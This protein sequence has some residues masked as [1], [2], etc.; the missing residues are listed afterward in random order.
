MRKFFTLMFVFGIV[1][2]FAQTATIKGKVTDKKTGEALIGANVV[3]DN[4]KGAAVDINGSYS[5]QTEPGTY[6]IVFKF[7]GYD[8]HEEKI[9]LA[10]NEVKTLDIKLSEGNQLEDVVVS[11]SKFEQKIGEVAISMNIIKPELIDN[12][13]ITTPEQIVDQCPGVQI[14]ENQV[15]IRGGSGFSYGSGSRVLLMVD[16]LPMLSADA[17]DIKWNSLPIENVEQMEVMKGASSVLYG[18]SALNGVINIRT[19]FPRSK[20]L[21]K[22]NISNGFYMNPSGTQKG[23]KPVYNDNGDLVG[24]EDSI[25]DRSIQQWNPNTNY[26]IA[27]NFLHSRQIKQQFDLVV[28]GNFFTNQGYRMGN[29]EHRGR[30]NFNTRYRSKKIEGLSFGVN[31]NL[32]K[33]KGADFFAWQNADSVFYPQGL[34]DTATTT[35]QYFDNIRVNLDPHATYFDNK[36]NRHML[37]S[38][39]FL[40]NNRNSANRASIANLYYVEYQYQKHWKNGLTVSFGAMNNYSTVVAPLYGNHFSNNTAA[41]AQADK[42]I[43]KFTFTGG[44]RMEYFRIDSVQTREYNKLIKDTLPFKPVFRI[45]TTYEVAEHTFLRA[46]YGEGYRFPTIAE[47]FIQTSVGALNIFPNSRLLAESG[48][49]AELG[50]KQGVKIGNFKGYL[51]IAGFV[52]GYNNMMEFTFGLYQADGSPWDYSQ[53][54]NIFTDFGAQAKNVENALIKGGEISLA[55]TGEIGKVNVTTLMGYTYIDPRTVNNEDSLY[56][57]TFSDTTNILKYRSKHMFKGDLQLDYKKFSFGV[58]AR[59]NSFQQNIDY[60]FVDPFIGSILLPGYKAYREARRKGDCI[61]DARLSMQVSKF[62]KVSVLMNNV[63]N[64]EYSSRPGNVMPPRTLIFQYSFKF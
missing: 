40:T 42:K 14:N 61:F 28:G 39:W 19:A 1:I 24:Y 16:D 2:S 45:G 35:L 4:G 58:S 20:P 30:I 8:N 52:T 7:V 63:F 11:A 62:A 57:A 59:Y 9:T 44:M 25:I 29:D 27:A 23:T 33:T 10:A 5:I 38:R 43:K 34:E 21:T 41:F 51:D 18:S 55:G 13:A 64:R 56:M 15:S 49:S 47:K 26:Y 46:S 3:L 50:I 31:G 37:R 22:I 48:W 36:G 32:N 53:I 17:G 12:K 60:T 54:P 6:I